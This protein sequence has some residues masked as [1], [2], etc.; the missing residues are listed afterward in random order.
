MA[1]LRPN[2]GRREPVDLQAHGRGALRAIMRGT[3]VR[4]E[5]PGFPVCLR[6]DRRVPEIVEHEIDDLFG[7]HPDQCTP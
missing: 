2:A 3:A 5:L 7:C 1:G 6:V 4:R